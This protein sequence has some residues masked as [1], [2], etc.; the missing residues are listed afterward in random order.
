MKIGRNRFSFLDCCLLRKIA[1]V[2]LLV[3]ATTGCDQQ[4]NA[5]VP[6]P[7]P[8]VTVATPARR[9]VIDYLEFN[10]NTQAV[11]TV[12]LRARVKGFL[13]QA[14]F[15]DGAL[16]KRGQLL[17]VIDPKPFEA[18][19]REGDAAVRTQKSRLE[20]AEIE[21][22]RYER[23]FKQNAA[24][25]T[26]VLKWRIERDSARADLAAAQARLD[27]AQLDLGYTQV[28]A[29]FD[30]R[31]GR[32][33]VDV[34]NL[35]GADTNTQLATLARLDPIYAYFNL[36][37][38]D[39]LRLTERADARKT[40]RQSAPDEEQYRRIRLEMGLA[41]QTGYPFHGRLDFAD[42]GLDPATGTLL[43]RGVFPNPDSRIKPGLFVRIRA[44]I[45]EIEN[46]IL[47]PER[48]IGADQ[49]GK[50]V[51]VV[52]DGN[53]VRQTPVKL[54]MTIDNMRVVLNGLSGNERVI[55]GGLQRARDGIVV[56]PDEGG[57]TTAKPT[58]S[59]AR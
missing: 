40:A 10:G 9:T 14:P 24:P 42:L 11:E 45:A 34:G 16:V 33:L 3:V 26:E 8:E 32:R 49:R 7:P 2:A 41:T 59:M 37:E 17:F 22:A 1:R 51:F 52:D 13:E 53:K 21:Y 23:L 54:G 28:R 57:D 29:P 25:E 47:V 44:P 15:E 46:A 43:L 56:M 55:V 18:A 50:Y 27:E 39:F 58:A 6:P 48:A 12:E 38:L 30:G 20:R 36:N 35:V 31:I 5:Y 19:V 4:D